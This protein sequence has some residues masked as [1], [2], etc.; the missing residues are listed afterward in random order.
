MSLGKALITKIEIEVRRALVVQYFVAH[1]VALALLL[2]P[3]YREHLR[4]HSYLIFD[5]VHVSVV[6]HCNFF[7]VPVCFDQCI[8]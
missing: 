4:Q 8:Y 5:V 7:I 6:E 1:K 3:S 2:S